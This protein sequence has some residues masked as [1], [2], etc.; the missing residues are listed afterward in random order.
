MTAGPMYELAI[1]RIFDAPREVVYQ[2]FVDPDQIAQWFGPVGF[3]VPRESVEVDPKPGGYHRLVMVSSAD[4]AVRSQVS[5]TLTEVVENELLV[6]EQTALGV[7]GF[8]GPVTMFLRVEFYDE[9]HGRTRIELRQGPYS[10]PLEA[11]AREGWNSS[12]GK[13]DELLAAHR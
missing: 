10:Q 6:G 13:L 2:A 1:S 9:G 5:A 11:D 7:P 4:P 12:F 3:T 8:E